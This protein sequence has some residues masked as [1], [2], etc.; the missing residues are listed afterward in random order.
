MMLLDLICFD[1]LLEQVKNGVPNENQGAAI[2]TPFEPVNN[3]GIYEIHCSKGHTSTTVIDNIDFEILF[4]YGLN[5]IADGFYREA[6]SSFTSAM[7]RYFEF[8]VKVTF[9]ISK[10]GFQDIDIAW[11][12]ISNQSERQLGAYIALYNYLFR[13]QPLL[14]NQNKEVPFRNKV[15]HKGYI[16]SRQ[17]ALEYGERSLKI[18]E[19]SLIKLKTKYRKSTFE[20]FD[21]YGYKYSAKTK[22][23]KEQDK[24]GIEKDIAIVNIL[25]MINIKNGREIHKDD[26]RNRDIE[27]FLEHILNMRNNRKLILKKRK[28]KSIS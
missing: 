10:L 17:E 21:Y 25:T 28:N 14:L 4:D 18:I 20:T 3:T 2:L 26:V 19:S 13:E 12:S 27:S 16:P 15:I 1:C 7:E 5:A 8:F 23:Q 22:F 9:R 24:T 11:N 6:V